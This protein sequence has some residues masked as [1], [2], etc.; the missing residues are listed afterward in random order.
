MHKDEINMPVEK[1][2][3]WPANER[4]A[5]IFNLSSVFDQYIENPGYDTKEVLVFLAC[6]HDFNQMSSGVVELRSDG[7]LCKAS[8]FCSLD[9]E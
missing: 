9:C 5:K 8:V 3:D 7:N 1:P 4:E 6:E 2:A